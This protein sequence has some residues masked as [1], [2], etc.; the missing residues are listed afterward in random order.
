MMTDKDHDLL[1]RIDER[2]GDILGEVKTLN[3]RVHNLERWRWILTG[4][5]ATVSLVFGG[6]ILLF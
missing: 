2:V 1:I 5:V 4:M 3:G 6:R